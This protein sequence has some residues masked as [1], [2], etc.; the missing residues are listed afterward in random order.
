MCPSLEDNR[1]CEL[2]LSSTHIL[3][4]TEGVHVARLMM[5]SSAEATHFSLKKGEGGLSQVLLCCLSLVLLNY[6]STLY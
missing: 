4:H 1:T 3:M 2:M 6:L 5:F